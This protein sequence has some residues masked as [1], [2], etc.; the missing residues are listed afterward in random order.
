MDGTWL[1]VIIDLLNGKIISTEE[2]R[3]NQQIRFNLQQQGIKPNC[4]GCR[5]NLTVDHVLQCNKCCLIN[6]LHN[7]VAD[8]WGALCATD[9][10]P[11]VVSHEP[12]IN[13]GG[14]QTRKRAPKA[15]PK[16]DEME[17]RE[18]EDRKWYNK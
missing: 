3:E 12:L 6:I 10:T 7:D 17:I 1:T 13:Y 14:Q 16:Y 18:E 9:Q 15:K 8:D 5:E 4:N 2:F 11:L